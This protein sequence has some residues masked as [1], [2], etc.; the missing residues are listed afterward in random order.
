MVRVINITW[1]YEK[2]A[3]LDSLA[4]LL[5]KKLKED[6]KLKVSVSSIENGIVF[7]E[8]E[9]NRLMLST[10]V[11]K[12]PLK[13]KDSRIKKLGRPYLETH[14]PTQKQYMGFFETI[15]KCL[16]EL[17][18]SATVDTVVKG[19]TYVI[20]DGKNKVNDFPKLNTYPVE[21]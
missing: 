15:N 18:L 21:K 4:A 1:T 17:G 9:K 8:V 20:R 3:K 5:S 10:I 6:F 19:T 13:D 2:F 12:I 14:K 11:N 16:D 7:R